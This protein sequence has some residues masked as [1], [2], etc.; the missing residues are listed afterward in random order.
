MD[1]VS[2]YSVSSLAVILEE[3]FAWLERTLA[4]ARGRNPEHIVVFQHIPWFIKSADED[5]RDPAKYPHLTPELVPANVP[6]MGLLR[7]EVK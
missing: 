1:S 6:V 7:S 3:Y 2:R 5:W 4:E